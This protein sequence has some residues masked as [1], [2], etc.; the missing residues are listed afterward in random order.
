[1]NQKVV[2]LHK[3]DLALWAKTKFCLDA[4]PSQT[5]IARIISASSSLEVEKIGMAKRNRRGKIP[6][7]E[8]S[9]AAWVRAH[10]AVKVCV[11]GEIIKM[12]EL[13]F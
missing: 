8:A 3:K 11:T 6:E 10:H 4:P 5:V 13:E 9:L 1:M 12:Q 2:Q 7:M